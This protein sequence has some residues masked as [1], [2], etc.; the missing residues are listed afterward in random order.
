[1]PIPIDNEGN[2]T[3]GGWNGVDCMNGLE[4]R[5]R[6]TE[7]AETIDDGTAALLVAG[8]RSFYAQM[9]YDRGPVPTSVLYMRL[10]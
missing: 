10:A 2:G 5:S 9:P 6:P 3:P 1:M 7:S 4:S 8:H